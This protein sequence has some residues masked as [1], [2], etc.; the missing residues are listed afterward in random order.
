MYQAHRVTVDLL[1]QDQ[2]YWRYVE[3]C[4]VDVC[5]RFGYQRIVTPVFEAAGL[6][7][8]SVGEQ[9]DVIQKETYTFED[10]GGDLLPLRP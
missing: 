1:P 4:A 9:T 10:R 6:F 8:R 7:V 2:K 5:Q 3:R